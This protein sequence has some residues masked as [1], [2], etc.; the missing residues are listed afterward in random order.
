MKHIFRKCIA[1]SLFLLSFQAGVVFAAGE[2]DH[3]LLSGMPGYKITYRQDIG[4]GSALENEK[5]YEYYC[6]SAGKACTS[7]NPGFNDKGQAIIEGKVTIIKYQSDKPAGALAILRNYENAVKSLGG[8]RVT[9]VVDTY[10]N[11]QQIFEVNKN[12][13][14]IWIF[15]GNDGNEQYDLLF[16]EEK[17]MQQSVTAGQLAES[18]QKTGIATIYINF[19]NNK[20]DLKPDAKPTVDEVVA[21]LKK[22]SALRISIDGHTDNVGQAPANK[23]LSEAR[24]QSVMKALVASGID[25]KRLQAKGFGSETPVADNRNDDGRAKNRRVELVKQK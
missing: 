21:L 12:G 16:V 24:A 2:K 22:D 6:S 15:L 13:A 11:S 17:P 1:I 7:A 9:Q 23:T 10:Y 19:D 8:R 3:P 20:A 25:T 18:I 14:K 5:N 4:F